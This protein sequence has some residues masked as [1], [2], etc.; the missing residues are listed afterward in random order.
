M[1]KL[2]RLYFYLR[3]WIAQASKKFFNFVSDTNTEFL[4]VRMQTYSAEE[5]SK[6]V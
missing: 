3:F 5:L 1:N 4:D 2:R 6:S